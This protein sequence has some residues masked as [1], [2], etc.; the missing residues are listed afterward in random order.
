M[1]NQQVGHLLV[2]SFL[3]QSNPRQ[4]I[5]GALGPSEASEKLHVRSGVVRAFEPMQVLS[6]LRCH[7]FFYVELLT[8]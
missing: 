3:R 5:G 1:E 4:F 6:D 8:Q 7:I 2:S